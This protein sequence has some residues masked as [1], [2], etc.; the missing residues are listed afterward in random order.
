MGY[1]LCFVRGR[2][3]YCTTLAVAPDLQGSRVAVQLLRALVGA[4]A[5]A[6]TRA[7]SR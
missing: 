5:A 6:S 4:L 7:G 1:V 3:A 2:E